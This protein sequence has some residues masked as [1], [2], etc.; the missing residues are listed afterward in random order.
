LVLAGVFIYAAIGKIMRPD[1]F[2][3]DISGYRILPM[4]YINLFAVTL[5]WIELFGGVAVF[6][7]GIVAKHGALLFL[8]MNTMFICAVAS[9]IARGLHIECG[10]FNQCSL[11]TNV[12]WIVIARD[13]GLLLLCLPVLFY[14]RSS[15]RSYS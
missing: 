3:D 2:A 11:E 7:P 9:A 8:G 15:V 12:G 5:P 10:C 13:V 14:P 4:A 1:E 6:L